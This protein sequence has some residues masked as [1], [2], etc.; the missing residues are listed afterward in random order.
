MARVR[1]L[2]RKARTRIVLVFALLAVSVVI[3]TV[4]T[5]LDA[6]GVKS[7]EVNVDPG[8]SKVDNVGCGFDN[9][10]DDIYEL[11]LTLKSDKGP[12]TASDI[13]TQASDG[14]LWAKDGGAVDK[15]KISGVHPNRRFWVIIWAKIGAGGGGGVGAK[16]KKWMSVSDLDADADTDNDST[17]NPR[18][19][20]ESQAEDFAEYDGYQPPDTVPGVAIGVNDDHDE[21]L[22]EATSWGR[23]LDNTTADLDKEGKNYDDQ[24]VGLC[25]L[26]V[27]IG[28][29]RSGMLKFEVPNV[30]RLFEG[31]GTLGGDEGA[32]FQG[33]R[34]INTPGNYTEPFY[35][36]GIMEDNTTRELTITFDPEGG[37]G[38][39]KDIVTILPVR[40]DID[41]DSDNSGGETPIDDDNDHDEDKEEAKPG[42]SGMM[43]EVVTD[44]ND[45]SK[46]KPGILRGLYSQ[47]VTFL[48]DDHTPV[49]TLKKLPATDGVVRVWKVLGG[50]DPPVLM[51]D[52]GAGDGSTTTDGTEGENNSLWDLLGDASDHD[53]LI[54]AT[55]PGVVLLGLELTVNGARVAMDVVQFNALDLDVDSD[56]NNALNAP[57]RND[58]E[59]KIEDDDTKPGKYVMVNDDDNDNG[60]DGDGIPDFAD[61]YNLESY[62]G[63]YITT[64]GEAFTPIVLELP[65]NINLAVA[66]VKFT[67]EASDPAAVSRTGTSP[68][69]VYTA[70]SGKLRIWTKDGAQARNPA[71]VGAATPGDYVPNGTY[72]ASKLG[73]AGDTYEVTLYIEGISPSASLGNSRILVEVD[74]DG[75]GPWGFVLVDAVRV[76]SIKVDVDV[77]SDNED[78]LNAP[79]R[80]L[81]EDHYEN[82]TG[83]PTTRPGKIVVTNEEDHD[84][85]LIPDYADGYDY[86]GTAGNQDDGVTGN[87]FIQLVIELAAP[88]DITKAKVKITYSDSI[89][90]SVTRTGSSSDNYMYTPGPKHLRIWTKQAS[91]AR[92]KRSIASSGDFVPAATYDATTL[93][94]TAGG[95]RTKT[96]YV[97]GVRPGA[98]QADQQIYVELDPDGVG[99]ASF[100]AK[101]VVRLSAAQVVFE[102]AA[103]N[104]NKY[105]YD[106]FALIDLQTVSGGAI[107]KKKFGPLYDFVS[108]MKSDS[109]KVVAKINGV[110][111]QYIQFVS[112]DTGTFTVSPTTGS[113]A[114][115]TLTITA[116]AKDKE[117]DDLEARD[118]CGIRFQ[119]V[120]V[121]VYK[122]KTDNYTLFNVKHNTAGKTDISFPTLAPNAS[123]T[124]ANTRLKQAVINVDIEGTGAATASTYDKNSNGILDLA[125]PGYSKSDEQTQIEADCT[126]AGRIRI[127]YV[128]DV[129]WNYYLTADAA[130]GTDQVQ[131]SSTT[132]ITVTS[133]Y[134]LEQGATSEQITVTAI[135]T[136][137][138]TL[139]VTG[140]GAGGKL[141]NSF[142]VAGK[143]ALIWPLGGLSSDGT[144]PI[145]VEDAGSQ[146]AVQAIMTHEIGHTTGNFRDLTAR[147]HVMFFGTWGFGDALR[148]RDLPLKYSTGNEKQ[149]DRVSR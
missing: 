105:G 107:T 63:N 18:V 24:S 66:K 141:A 134:Q 145:F 29:K 115:Q 119:R 104:D 33:D 98:T 65:D 79:D 56:N 116:A 85:D 142:T 100:V 147:G 109:T 55:S 74:P 78:G 53:V 51:L 31:G 148:Y 125:G 99:N 49:I 137:T 10:S 12:I 91:T 20:S 35:I 39:A 121:C 140:A 131:L 50:E 15:Y 3:A 82:K 120:G 110:Q 93:G 86:D 87:K 146:A 92:D 32:A 43:V 40:M 123:E 112:T 26:V 41:V 23:D 67:Y 58:D 57:D 64:T 88:I 101:D 81:V 122:Q 34:A 117:K 95:T 77:D 75:G 128:H 118:P 108:V 44:P 132:Y 61:G 42:L 143:A 48:L 27:K 106:A 17:A 102:A 68:N 1:H 144:S 2:W 80:N 138:N 47:N 16:P 130:A 127:I 133:T 9:L 111:P 13:D 4:A 97:E 113:V 62:G 30:I 114:P 6:A 83:G 129:R 139:T 5:T 59:D 38:L 70:A 7:K 72:D 126:A 60:G 25:K 45:R 69:Y 11:K 52:T 36:E 54:T 149:W 94:F 89:P 46:A 136:A 76:T 135:N 37:E 73:L 103:G 124:Y 84:N 22:P 71:S 96:F 28:A 19:P 21:F 90:S 8:P 14:T